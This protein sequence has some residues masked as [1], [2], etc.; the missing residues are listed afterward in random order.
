MF[1][2]ILRVLFKLPATPLIT[3]FLL[4]AL[5]MIYLSMFFEWLYDADAHD[6]RSTQ[7]M[8]QDALGAL[9]KWYTTV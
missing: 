5:A 8:K 4:F 2:K 9:K 7:G 6:K 3:I 1:K